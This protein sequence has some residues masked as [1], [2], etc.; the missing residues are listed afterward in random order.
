[1]SLPPASSTANPQWTW[2]NGVPTRTSCDWG[3]ASFVTNEAGVAYVPSPFPLQRGDVLIVT[4]LCTEH[5]APRGSPW[6]DALLFIAIV[7]CVTILMLRAFA[8]D[9]HQEGESDDH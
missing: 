7:V 4:P 9:R 3:T 1:M 6:P 8:G 2:V 5:V